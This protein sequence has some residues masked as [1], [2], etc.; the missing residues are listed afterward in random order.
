MAYQDNL[1]KVEFLDDRRNIFSEG[2]H[3]PVPAAKT[4]LPVAGKVDSHDFVPLC[5]VG[6]LKLP[7]ASIAAPAMNKYECWSAFA[8]YIVTYG[9]IV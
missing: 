9:H 3:S 4:G 7:V 8:L 1:A 6:H 2:L 5:K